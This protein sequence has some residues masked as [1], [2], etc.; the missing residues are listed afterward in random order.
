LSPPAVRLRGVGRVF[1]GRRVLG[2][3]DLT[4]RRGE[5]VVLVGKS[6][7]GKSTLLKIVGGLDA[8]AEGEVDV[9]DNRAVVFQDPRLLPWKPVWKNVIL[10]L[11]GPAAALR[12]RAGA[13]LAEVGLT[14][15]AGAWPLTLSGGEAQRVAIARAL[16]REP[17]LLLM[18]EPFAA[19]D[20][21]TRLKMQRQVAGLWRRHAIATLFVTHDV[22]EALLLADRVILIEAGHIERELLVDLAR[23]RRRE[24]PRFL[25]LRRELLANLGVESEDA[26]DSEE[27]VERGALRLV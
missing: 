12:A 17:D 23:P 1:E 3:V 19:L 7:C 16:V 4:I 14:E 8:E 9:V 25:A 10:G 18:D 6:G 2:D 20:A 5:F 21:L 27:F 26:A 11:D 24:H 22:D 15:R 13:A